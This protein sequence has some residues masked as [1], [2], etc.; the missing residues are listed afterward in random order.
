MVAV[1]ISSLSAAA[2]DLVAGL[3]AD[4]TALPAPEEDC[5]AANTA[6]TKNVRTNGAVMA[7]NLLLAAIIRSSFIAR[8]TGGCNCDSSAPLELG[9]GF[10][11]THGLRPFGRLRAGCGLHP[12]AASRLTPFH[13]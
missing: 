11:F 12:F 3:E 8:I 1:L 5:A 6:S 7:R 2:V 10:S 13:A 4:D 9:S